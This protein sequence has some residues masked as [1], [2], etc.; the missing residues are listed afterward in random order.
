MRTYTINSIDRIRLNLLKLKPAKVLGEVY[1]FYRKSMEKYFDRNGNPKKDYFEEV[2]CPVCKSTRHRHKINID[3]FEYRQCVLCG[4]VYNSPRLKDGVL[5]L[6]YKSGEYNTYFKKLT[7][8]SQRLRKNVIELRKFKQLSTFFHKPGSLLDVGCGTGSFLKVCQEHGWRVCGVDPSKSAVQV[9]K[10]KYGI[11]IENN[12]FDSYKAEIKFD[13]I[14]FWGQLEHLSN[15]MNALKKAVGLLKKG[16]LIIFE[17]PSA[18]SFLMRYLVS[19][20]FSPYR[21]IENARHLIFFSK[22][23]IERICTVFDLSL[24]YLESNGLDLQT[25]LPYNFNRKLIEKIISM[26]QIIDENM[27][28]DH[29]RVFLKRRKK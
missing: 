4:S 5:D 29:Y 13:C 25:I 11:E 24:S 26:Q 20:K 28:G 2:N 22:L 14:T 17:V 18:D 15:P 12:Y 21:Y 27:L 9:A 16:G 3:D 1:S 7:V 10:D 23:S 19:N 8:S 6:M